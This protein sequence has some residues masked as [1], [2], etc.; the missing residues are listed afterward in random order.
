MLLEV[1]GYGARIAKVTAEV[2][3][4]EAGSRRSSRTGLP[5]EYGRPRP[6]SRRGMPDW[7]WMRP[8]RRCKWSCPRLDMAGQTY[9]RVARAVR[10]TLALVKRIEAGW[11]RR[12]G[13]DDRRTMARRQV[14]RGVGERIARHADGERAERLFDDLNERLEAMDFDG[15]LDR[16]VQAVIEALCCKLGLPPEPE[17]GRMGGQGGAQGARRRRSG[18]LSGVRGCV[19]AEEARRGGAACV[20]LRGWPDQVRP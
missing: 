10:R 5:K 13:S 14:A 2:A 15:G 11:P 9:E 20:A 3:E 18:R 12:G 17:T 7:P 19:G 8:M 1:A 16:P 6:P 4:I